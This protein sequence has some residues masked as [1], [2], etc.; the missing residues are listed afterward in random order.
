[1]IIQCKNCARRFIARDSDIPENGRTVQC[2][3]CSVTWHQMPEIKTNKP[4]KKISKKLIDVISNKTSKYE[5]KASDGKKYK[6]LG[7]Q[8]AQLLP[9]GK[10]G[11]FAK[12]KIGVELDN[13]AGIVSKKSSNKFSRK[14]KVVDPSSESQIGREKLPD[15]YKPKNGIGF[16]GYTFILL[17]ISLSLLGAIKTFEDYWLD[18]FPQH[19][20]FFAFID[21]Q[22]DFFVETVKNMITILNDLINSY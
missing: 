14:S 17:I 21:Q 5:I 12:K 19:I 4:I 20:L 22:L 7:N 9:S 2:G 13:I 8:W 6:Y 15:I 1:M 11:I 10:T 18:Y 16:F 3:Y